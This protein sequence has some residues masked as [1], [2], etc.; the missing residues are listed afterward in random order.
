MAGGS[1]DYA[2]RLVW[3][4]NRGSGTADYRAY[5]RE[6]R[7]E[8]AGKP[9]LAGSAD[10]MFR[11]DPERLNPEDLFVAALSACHLLTYLALC[12][13]SGIR[14]VAYEDDARGTLA[15]DTAGGGRFESVTLR[16]RVTIAAGDR[17]LAA[18]L[19]EK[20]H[21][22]CFVAASVAIPVTVEPEILAR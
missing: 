5:G 10:P 22:L 1:H 8:F 2:A 16:P 11:G 9:D 3:E 18:A 6:Y 17:E 13:R 20:A 12:A 19:H 21:G 4:G 14:V 15:L 7:V